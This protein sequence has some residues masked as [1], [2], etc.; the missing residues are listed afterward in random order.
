MELTNGKI[1]NPFNKSRA[2][3]KRAS[4]FPTKF[5][6]LRQLRR[7]EHKNNGTKNDPR[8][9]LKV[10]FGCW[11]ALSGSG[12]PSDNKSLQHFWIYISPQVRH[13]LF[14]ENCTQQKGK[15]IYMPNPWPCT[16]SL[17]GIHQSVFSLAETTS[18]LNE[19]RNQVPSGLHGRRLIWYYIA[20]NIIN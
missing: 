19:N 12:F 9:S 14:F 5:V 1:K 15:K 8:M 18:S 20:S 4:E 16:C 10:A 6:Q 17:S 11:Q 3:N 2:L 7:C 13:H